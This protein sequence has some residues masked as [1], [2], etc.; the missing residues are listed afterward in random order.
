[1]LRYF[2]VL[3]FQRQHLNPKFLQMQKGLKNTDPQNN[4]VKKWVTMGLYI[5]V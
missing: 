3:G 1:M 5:N 2:F 4:C